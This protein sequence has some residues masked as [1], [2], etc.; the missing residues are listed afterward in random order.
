MRLEDELKTIILRELKLEDVDP[1]EIEDDTPLFYEGLGLDSLD[2]LELIV[3]M[4]NHYG[5]NIKDR[6]E[7]RQIFT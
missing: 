3:I 2:S 7:A 5:V 1:S 6:H 4:R